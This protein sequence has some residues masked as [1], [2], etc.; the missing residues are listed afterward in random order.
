MVN[1]D[2]GVG[3]GGKS[4]KGHGFWNGCPPRRELDSPVPG[5]GGGVGMGVT[6]GTGEGAESAVR[7]ARR[8]TVAGAAEAAGTVATGF[9]T[10][11]DS[12]PLPSLLWPPL[13]LQHPLPRRPAG[14]SPP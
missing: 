11:A 13:L 9:C 4:V 10:A 8:L 1:G 6:A 3:L 7:S 12:G 14:H 2:K 5:A